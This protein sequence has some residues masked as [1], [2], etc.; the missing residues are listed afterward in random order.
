MPCNFLK[1]QSLARCSLSAVKKIVRLC[2]CKLLFQALFLSNALVSVLLLLL[3]LLLLVAAL[4]L[5]TLP[6]AMQ[7]PPRS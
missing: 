5:P 6:P 4:L 3:P 2:V 7:L 1:L